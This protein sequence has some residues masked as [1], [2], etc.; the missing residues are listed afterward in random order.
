VVAF[1]RAVARGDEAS[2]EEAVSLYRGP[3]LEGCQEEWLFQERRLREEACLEA[4]ETLAAGALDRGEGGMAEGYLRR[5]VALDPL[6]ETAQRALMQALAAAGN[7]AA[8]LQSYRDLR[9][10]LHQELN[11][12][13]DPETQA[14]FQH[15]RAGARGKAA[16]G[17]GGRV[18][19]L[20]PAS[21]E[22]CTLPPA[23]P[24]P[25]GTVTFLLTDIEGS[26]RFWEEQPEAMRQALARHDA[27]AASIIGQNGGTLLKRRGEGDSLFAV[28]AQATHALA[29]ATAFQQALI[30]E[31]WPTLTPLRVRMALH[32]GE[33]D[34]QEEDYYG[35]TVNR[36]ARLRGAAHGGQ[37]LLSQAT[38]SLVREELPEGAR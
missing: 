22:L 35:P 29:A 32:T 30:C 6:R 25:V 3:L 38:R 31:A 16:K 2:L 12:E 11:A 28:F 21:P 18:Q 20:E 7:Y 5:A 27:L 23:P 4:L 1:D 37:V 10:R 26:T 15:L 14:L 33:A 8:V 24:L 36:C 9:Q 19:S 13:P 17:A 34:H